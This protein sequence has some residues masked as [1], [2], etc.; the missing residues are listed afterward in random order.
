MEKII[1]ECAAR[2]ARWVDPDFGPD[3]RS[4]GSARLCT[5][6]RPSEFMRPHEPVLFDNDAEPDDIAQGELGDCYFL[7]ALS[8]LAEDPKRIARLFE[9]HMPNEYGV[10]CA[11]FYPNGIYTQVIV[12]DLMPC[13]PDS[14]QPMYSRNKGPELWVLLLEKAYSKVFGSYANIDT[15][16]TIKALFDLTGCP[17]SGMSVRA[18]AQ[19]R[20][21]FACSVQAEED[22]RRACARPHAEERP[23]G[24][25]DVLQ[26]RRH[27]HRESPRRHRPGGGPRVRPAGH[28][29][30][31]WGRQQGRAHRQDQKPV[32]KRAFTHRALPDDSDRRRSGR[33]RGRTGTRGGWPRARPCGPS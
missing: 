14:R 27:P 3:A 26:H 25:R 11:T 21:T 28:R 17:G 31:R 13:H 19:W 29:G 33:A 18:R 1:A 9:D 23:H 4:L 12:D 5:W 32:G 7:S 10:Y 15:G 8:V 20:L 30:R 22:A 16:T 2:G 24:Q 6:V